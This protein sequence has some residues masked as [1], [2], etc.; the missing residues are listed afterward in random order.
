MDTGNCMNSQWD[1]K[2]IK[3]TIEKKMADTQKAKKKI[4]R[5]P[6]NQNTSETT[7]NMI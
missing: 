6:P 5:I 3:T 2:M 4:A 7:A 1:W